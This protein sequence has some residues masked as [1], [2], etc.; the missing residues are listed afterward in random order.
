MIFTRMLYCTLVA[1]LLGL[2][3]A[4]LERALGALGGA[5]RGAWAA[6][7]LLSAAFP[8]AL[9]RLMELRAAPVAPAAAAGAVGGPG[10]LPMSAPAVAS[11]PTALEAADLL[12][13]PAWSSPPRSPRRGAASP[14]WT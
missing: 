5:T 9:P 14:A 8:V 13:L 3:A 7:I 2:G 1:A 10:A 12:L 4:A 11:G 6:A